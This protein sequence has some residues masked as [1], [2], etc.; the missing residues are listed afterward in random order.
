[1]RLLALPR[2]RALPPVDWQR[3]NIV[4]A[5]SMFEALASVMACE[6]AAS[7]A[8]PCGCGCGGGGVGKR[9]C[10][11]GDVATGGG[12]CVATGGGEVTTGGGG[13]GLAVGGGVVAT[14]GVGGLEGALRFT[15][16]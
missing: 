4:T 15:T 2:A 9:G 12:G 1:M 16:G 7:P 14:G 5:A 3:L 10:G 13:G 6:Q 8:G 11:G